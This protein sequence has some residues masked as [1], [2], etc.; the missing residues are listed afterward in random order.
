[1]HHSRQSPCLVLSGAL[2]D[3]VVLCRSFGGLG[4]LN[5]LG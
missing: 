3:L 2:G 5:V 1:M 4:A